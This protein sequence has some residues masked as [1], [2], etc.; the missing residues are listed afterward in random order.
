MLWGDIVDK[1]GTYRSWGVFLPALLSR[2]VFPMLVLV[3]KK[4]AQVLD[5]LAW[6]VARFAASQCWGKQL[7]I[8]GAAEL[9]LH[10]GRVHQKE[11]ISGGIGKWL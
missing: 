7:R 5:L 8:S 4:K 11:V 2:E 3:G 9:S 1:W 10:S 6:P